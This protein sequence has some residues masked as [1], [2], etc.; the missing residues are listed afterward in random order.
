MIPYFTKRL[1]IENS[2]INL[3]FNRIYTA[4]G[5]KYHVSCID[6]KSRKVI[7]FYMTENW[8]KWAVVNSQ[9]CPDW[10]QKLEPTF[11]EYILSNQISED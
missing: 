9:N 1:E 11:S 6:P 4:E 3:Y 2:Y 7:S 5:A 8:G 10:I